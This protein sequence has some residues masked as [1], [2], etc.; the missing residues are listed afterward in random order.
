MA[1]RVGMKVCCIDDV[2]HTEWHRPDIKYIGN[3][4]GLRKG[5]VYTV[6]GMFMDHTEGRTMLRLVE[7]ERNIWCGFEV[8]YSPL[9]FRPVVERKTDISIFQKL[10]VHSEMEGSHV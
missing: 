9:R 10:L 4:D 5:Q 1:F 6:R 7:I 8:G 3:L 2:V